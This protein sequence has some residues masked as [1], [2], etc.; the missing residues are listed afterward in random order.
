MW[1]SISYIF[2][3][4]VL[5]STAESSNQAAG[6]PV[7]EAPPAPKVDKKRRCKRASPACDTSKIKEDPNNPGQVDQSLLCEAGPACQVEECGWLGGTCETTKKEA[8]PNS[9]LPPTAPPNT[10][11]PPNQGY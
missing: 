8:P 4:N 3:F 1:K 9:Y 5:C 10:Y 6:E 11:L 7:T 2:V